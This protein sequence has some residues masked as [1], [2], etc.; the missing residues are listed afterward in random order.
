MNWNTKTKAQRSQSHTY[1]QTHTENMWRLL[2]EYFIREKVIDVCVCVS[3]CSLCLCVYARLFYAF[4]RAER[5]ELSLCAVRI[6]KNDLWQIRCLE[7]A[8]ARATCL[9]IE[10]G[11]GRACQ[12]RHK[13]SR[14]CWLLVHV[15]VLHVMWTTCALQ[16]SRTR[17][18]KHRAHKRII[19]ATAHGLKVI[20][21]R[22]T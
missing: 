21:R 20:F 7:R 4:E 2:V 17:H 19:F 10:L 8:S 22:R 1:T 5:A 12:A 15:V 11:L 16:R 14:R 3:V 18:H 6:T 13:S 9:R